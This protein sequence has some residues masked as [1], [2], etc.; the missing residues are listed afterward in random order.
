[1]GIKRFN[2]YL[3]EAQLRKLEAISEKTL[4]PVAPLIRKAVEEHLKK[5]AK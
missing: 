5:N 1:M 4:A 2:L 3:P